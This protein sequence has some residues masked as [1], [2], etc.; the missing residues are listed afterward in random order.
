MLSSPPYMFN[1]LTKIVC[2]REVQP[3]HFRRLRLQSYPPGFSCPFVF[4]HLH[5]YLNNLGRHCGLFPVLYIYSKPAASLLVHSV[6]LL[7]ASAQKQ[8][9][10]KAWTHVSLVLFAASQNSFILR[11]VLMGNILPGI[12]CLVFIGFNLATYL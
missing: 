3:C 12:L 4:F 11:W 9:D 1:R 10:Q 6:P 7:W 2:K 8:W 5:T